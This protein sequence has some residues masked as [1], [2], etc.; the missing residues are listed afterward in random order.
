MSAEEQAALCCALQ[1]RKSAEL[2]AIALEEDCFT[3]EP[4]RTI[5]N[6]I[7]SALALAEYDT[8]GVMIAAG[9]LGMLTEDFLDVTA[10]IADTA[11]SGANT[12]HFVSKALESRSNRRILDTS[13]RI[14]S[15]EI[16]PQ[17]AAGA[18]QNEYQ[19]AERNRRHRL[20][21][22][23]S[24][25]TRVIEEAEKPEEYS[26]M[27]KTGFRF[28]D[29]ELGGLPRSAFVIVGAATGVGKSSFALQLALEVASQAR[30]L[31]FSYEMTK[32]ENAKRMLSQHGAPTESSIRPGMRKDALD[33]ASAVSAR[34][35]RRDMHL[36][37]DTSLSVEDVCAICRRE[38]MN[39]E[40]GLVVVDYIQLI[41]NQGKESRERE[42]A[43]VSRN[44]RRLSLDIGV[45]V[46]ALA[47]LNR[48]LN[49]RDDKEPRLSDLRESGSLEQDATMV[50]LL[51]RPAAVDHD[52]NNQIDPTEALVKVAKNR[53][54]KAHFS[55]RARFDP[56]SVRFIC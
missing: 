51:H 41:K 56:E 21:P 10:A 47:Q 36:C 14:A 18:L 9:E 43:E 33:L 15:G 3:S 24:V 25:L 1:S 53:H 45:P 23:N 32:D 4:R 31:L 27:L 29:N 46:V 39:K 19:R 54:G 49:S 52:P 48:Q 37:S 6:A 34:I 13:K 5:F 28:W 26:P 16:S 11:A 17:E 12:E 8:A 42:V 50:L 44:L 35:Q 38:A 40:L 20:E 22:L 30:V 55:Q 2:V 7:C